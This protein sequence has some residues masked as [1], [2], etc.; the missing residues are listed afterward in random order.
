MNEWINKWMKERS[1]EG[2][3]KRTNKWIKGG[4]QWMNE[5][6]NKWMNGNKFCWLDYLNWNQLR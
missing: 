5:Q 3:H 6:T 4:I 1:K 2:T